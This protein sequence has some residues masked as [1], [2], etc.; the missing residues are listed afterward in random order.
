MVD[1]IVG[2]FQDMINVTDGRME[3]W[4]NGRMWN[5]WFSNHVK[6]LSQNPFGRDQSKE[7]D[8][9]IGMAPDFF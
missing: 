1:G 8:Q 9:K 4:K 3:E 2:G 6:F 7:Q 5:Q